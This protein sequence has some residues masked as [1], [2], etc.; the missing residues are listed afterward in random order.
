[1]A[2]LSREP[3]RYEAQAPDRYLRAVEEY[4]LY[5]RESIE[6]TYANSISKKMS[7]LEQRIAA[8][9]ARAK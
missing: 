4:L 3:P 6:H 5:L 2:I 1:M 7:E 8:L 9:E